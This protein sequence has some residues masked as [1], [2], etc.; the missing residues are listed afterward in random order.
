MR[1]SDEILDKRIEQIKAAANWLGEDKYDF[2]GDILD[3]LLDLRDMR[4]VERKK[5]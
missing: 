3:T 2:N 1:I 5:R 4:I